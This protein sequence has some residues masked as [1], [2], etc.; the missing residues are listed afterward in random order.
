M[1]MGTKKPTRGLEL[2]TL[3]VSR[4]T[5]RFKTETKSRRTKYRP[6][7]SITLTQNLT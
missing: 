7:E 1:K 2:K 6:M 5:L 3:K 4:P